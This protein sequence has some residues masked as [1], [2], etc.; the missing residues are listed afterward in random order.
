MPHFHPKLINITDFGAVVGPCNFCWII[1]DYLYIE[2]KSIL[3]IA[4]T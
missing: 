4:L 1:S 3:L 2:G